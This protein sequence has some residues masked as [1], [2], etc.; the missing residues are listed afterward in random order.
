MWLKSPYCAMCGR[1]TEYP[2]G[3]E[4]DHI[5]PLFAGGTDDESNCQVLCN[6]DDGCHK[7]K[8]R[9]DQAKYRGHR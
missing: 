5:I 7:I 1:V 4:L 6:G 9:S 8:T 2:S 3:F